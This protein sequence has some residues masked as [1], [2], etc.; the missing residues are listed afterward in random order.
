MRALQH[1]H[2]LNRLGYKPYLLS[3]FHRG[4]EAAVERMQGVLRRLTREVVMLPAP[5]P[6]SDGLIGTLSRNVRYLM[7]LPRSRGWRVSQP[8]ESDRYPLARAFDAASAA[9]HLLRLV[10]EKRI[11]L[12][13]IMH[14]W[15]L[16][17]LPA[18]RERRPSLQV[19]LDLVDLDSDLFA[20]LF[21]S[22]GRLSEQVRR[23]V[24]W[25]TM[26]RLERTYFPMCDEFWAIAPT[27]ADKIRGLCADRPIVI[28]PSVIDVDRVLPCESDG[29]P[30][31]LVFLGSLFFPPNQNAVTHLLK[32]LYP[33]IRRAKAA[34][35]L[36]IVGR[37]LSPAVERLARQTPGVTLSGYVPETRPFYEDAQ[38]VVVPMREGCGVR[39]KILE[40][41]AMGRAV[42]ATPKAAEGLEVIDGKHIVIAD[43][44][45]AFVAATLDLLRRPDRRRA[46]G[47]NGRAL[48]ECR[49]SWQAA[50][51]IM[52]ADT[53]LRHS[54]GGM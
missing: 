14:A 29:L 41:L 37:G 10:M 11:D 1:L 22:G 35:H 48:V 5:M 43:S 9:E 26:R 20:Q 30:G 25:V 44:D 45:D 54:V 3:F 28:V 16:H 34:T 23:V 8:Y 12:L 18:V 46:L 39:V 2:L 4:Q 15:L 50:E 51:R 53:C 36:A 27:E 42:V 38:V 19:V 49:Y 24:G 17:Y 40:A 52:A 31:H 32:T 6:A 33:R 13:I 47:Q 7:P 21:R